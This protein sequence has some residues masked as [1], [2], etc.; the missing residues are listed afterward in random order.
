M[1]PQSGHGGNVSSRDI[2]TFGAWPQAL[3]YS[4]AIVHVSPVFGIGN[5]LSLRAAFRLIATDTD[6]NWIDREAMVRRFVG[7]VAIAPITYGSRT[8]GSPT[9]Y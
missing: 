7:P 9:S 1:S 4:P 3:M 5:I 6:D 2:V 8:G